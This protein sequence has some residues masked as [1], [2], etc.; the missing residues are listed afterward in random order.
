MWHLDLTNLK[1]IDH[2]NWEKSF[3]TINQDLLTWKPYIVY[4]FFC[5]PR[6]TVFLNNNFKGTWSQTI[7][8]VC[9]KT[10]LLAGGYYSNT[11][12]QGQWVQLPLPAS[13]LLPLFPLPHSL[14]RTLALNVPLHSNYPAHIQTH[15]KADTSHTLQS[16]VYVTTIQRHPPPRNTHTPYT[17]TPLLVPNPITPQ[18]SGSGAVTQPISIGADLF[19]L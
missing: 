7:P 9:A 15:T 5:S 14:D 12:V 16:L 17:T 13:C 4:V 6:L 2:Q 19:F 3:N 10:F 8:S 1:P 11:V 18:Q